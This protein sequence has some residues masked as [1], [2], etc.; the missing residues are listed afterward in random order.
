MHLEGQAREVAQV[1]GA[2]LQDLEIVPRPLG[3]LL[4]ARGVVCVT[5]GRGARISKVARANARDARAGYA[6]REAWWRV[7]GWR[8]GGWCGRCAQRAFSEMMLSVCLSRSRK[9]FLSRI[10]TCG[11]KRRA[12]ER[13]HGERGP[14]VTSSVAFAS[15]AGMKASLRPTACAQQARS[16]RAADAQRTHL[17]V[18]LCA[19]GGHA[20]GGGRKESN[21]TDHRA[22]LQRDD[23]AH[24][25]VGHLRGGRRQ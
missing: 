10:S 21:L 25:R 9:D 13:S 22:R 5:R 7:A 6:P 23:V 8:V 18:V 1:G 15:G 3:G 4:G 12:H 17:A 11:G 20:L 16:R 2:L 14:A 19:D 24:V